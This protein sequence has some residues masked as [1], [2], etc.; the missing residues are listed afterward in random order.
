MI[1][2]AVHDADRVQHAPADEVRVAPQPEWSAGV[3]E[4]VNELLARAAGQWPDRPYLENNGV[5]H[6]YSEIA[7][8][9]AS[10]AAGLAALGVQ[11]G[12]R[13]VM[14]LDN[15]VECAQVWFA[16]NWLGAIWVPLNTA[17]KGEFLRHQIHNAGAA[18]VITES[19]FV[20][21]L[22]P[23]AD[24][25][26][27][28][29]TV[30]TREPVGHDMPWR[31]ETLAVLLT[32]DRPHVPMVTVAPGDLAMF[33]YTSGTT[34]PSK[35]CMISH[36]YVCNLARQYLAGTARTP[37]E[38][39]WTALPLF[40]MNAASTAVLSTLMIGSKVYLATRFS[41]SGFWREIEESG[42]RIATLL[43]AMLT[44][45]ANAP[46]T[47]AEKRCFGQ[48]RVV[49]GAPFPAS[50]QEHWKQR[51]GGEI[52]GSNAF[53]LTEASLVTMADAA[54][55]PPPGSAGRRGP[56]F[57]V[58]IVDA[59][60]CEV[61]TGE[62]GEIVVRPR[63]PNIM[64][65]GYWR[66]PDA[67]AE[68]MRNLWFHTGDLGYFDDDDW[69]YF[70]D[71][72]KDYLRRRG[73]NISSYELESTFHQHPAVRECAVHAVPSDL[74][75][76]EVKVTVTLREG[77]T[78]TPYDLCEWSLDRLPYFAVPRYVEIRDE[79][80]KNALGKILKYELRDEGVT[81]STWDREQ[82]DLE[83]RR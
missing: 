11:R 55:T 39:A 21:R 16:V 17:N 69:L 27:E 74:T 36:N 28:V 54:A 35:G 76:D 10:L 25:I 19:R 29:T 72:K 7:E 6:T 34:G 42:A 64:F 26:P 62:V 2:T 83:V 22:V 4:T 31:A 41:V 20:E 50:L 43:G 23:I 68:V 80:P 14:L 15:S 81:S 52:F 61:P 1:D 9:A 71:R 8:S 51:F 53:G 37:E 82:S 44:M 49:R 57:D 77:A 40:H 66:R 30:V 78:V 38:V 5:V 60:D 45:V 48:L 56:D 79:L 65:A 12:D 70:A 33:I 58:R 3:Q 59:Q 47:E 73:E 13:V 67:T 32:A 75:E 18:V 46:E 24:G 63:R